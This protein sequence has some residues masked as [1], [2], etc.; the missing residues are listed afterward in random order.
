MW[1]EF[2]R[3]ATWWAVAK[4]SAL[5]LVP[6]ALVLLVHWWF[7]PDIILDAVSFLKEKVGKGGA[8]LVVGGGF[9]LIIFVGLVLAKAKSKQNCVGCEDL[10]VRVQGGERS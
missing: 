3:P 4:E 5:L 7:G 1:R 10:E 8:L 9:M 6:S 2:V